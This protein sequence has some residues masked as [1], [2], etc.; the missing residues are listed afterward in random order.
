MTRLLDQCSD[1]QMSGS[2]A[3]GQNP[4][5]NRLGLTLTFM[6]FKARNRQLF[7]FIINNSG[8]NSLYIL[9]GLRYFY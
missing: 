2:D 1:F 3:Y 7:I 5:I 4:E 8:L 9:F 6:T